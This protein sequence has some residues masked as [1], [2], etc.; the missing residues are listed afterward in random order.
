MY[1]E[2]HLGRIAQA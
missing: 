2:T 1:Q